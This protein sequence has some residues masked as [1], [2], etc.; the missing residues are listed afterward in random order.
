MKY[1]SKEGL[2]WIMVAFILLVGGISIKTGLLSIDFVKGK[3]NSFAAT[4]T[5]QYTDQ[6]GLD[7]KDGEERQGYEVI[8]LIDRMKSSYN[9]RMRAVVETRSGD[10]TTYGYA[11]STSDT[12]TA[13]TVTDKTDNDYIVPTDYYEVDVIEQGANDT[14]VGYTLTY[15]HQ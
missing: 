4:M 11:T 14:V 15:I 9:P 12:Y 5:E 3:A 13:Y 2:T 6:T 10:S 1:L 7:F 8:T